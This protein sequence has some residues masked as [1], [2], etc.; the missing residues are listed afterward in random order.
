MR[1]SL[2]SEVTCVNLTFDKRAAT[3]LFLL[4]TF[5][6]RCLLHRWMVKQAGTVQFVHA[7]HGALEK[8]LR[9]VDGADSP[10]QR[11]RRTTVALIDP[12]PSAHSVQLTLHL[13]SQVSLSP[14]VQTLHAL[15]LC[16]VQRFR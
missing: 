12:G 2:S 9:V 3:S 4:L 15:F 8:R 7:V 6:S 1:D 11:W 13:S 14:V 10:W 16:E 5:L